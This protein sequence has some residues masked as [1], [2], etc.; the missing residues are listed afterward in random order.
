MPKLQRFVTAVL[1]LFVA[2]ALVAHAKPRIEKAADVPRFT[3]RIE[4]SVEDLVRD[5]A[6]F[7][8]F[9]RDVR[10]DTESVLSGTRSTIGRRCASSKASSRS[11]TG[12]R[13]TTRVRSRAPSASR[14][15]RRSRPTS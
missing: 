6:K 13:A 11:S 1:A 2:T 10:R 15:C 14:R 7:A 8:R 4:G 9:A 12:S 5:E 3:Y